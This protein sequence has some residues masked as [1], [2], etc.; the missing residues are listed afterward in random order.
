MSKKLYVGGLSWETTE[1]DLRTAFGRLGEISEVSIIT[2][3]NTGRS[4]GFGFVTFDE[5]EAADNAIRELDN[6]VLDNRTIKVNQA[7]DRRQRNGG[8]GG[9]QGRRW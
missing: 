8:G 3:R 5:T 9:R 7:Q 2:D 1:S 6:T 4:R